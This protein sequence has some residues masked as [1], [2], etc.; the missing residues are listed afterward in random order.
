LNPEKGF[1][2]FKKL[3]VTYKTQ[4]SDALYDLINSQMPAED[5]DFQTRPCSTRATPPGFRKLKK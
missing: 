3:L 1:G 2:E 4:N 5:K